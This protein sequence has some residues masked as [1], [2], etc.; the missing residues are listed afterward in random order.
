ML[1]SFVILIH[2]QRRKKEP[3]LRNFGHQ[4]GL[5]AS[6]G[7]ILLYVVKRIQPIVVGATPGQLGLGC[8]Q[9]EAEQVRGSMPVRNIP[10]PWF[11]PW[12]PALASLDDRL[13]SARE[14]ISLGS[15]LRQSLRDCI[16]IHRRKGMLTTLAKD[17]GPK[18][19]IQ[20]TDQNKWRRNHRN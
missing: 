7:H 16:I 1:I 5:R 3:Q 17:I 9:V 15:I 20:H 18:L 11:F 2:F 4:I 6:L 10:P 8:I 19:N 13:E 14:L 12:V